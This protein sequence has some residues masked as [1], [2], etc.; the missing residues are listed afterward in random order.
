MVDLRSGLRTKTRGRYVPLVRQ[1]LLAILVPVAILLGSLGAIAAQAVIVPDRDGDGLPDAAE[2]RL[3]TFLKN[4]WDSDNDGI[5]DAVEDANHNGVVD[6]GETDPA[7]PD[8]DGDGLVDGF[9]MNAAADLPHGVRSGADAQTYWHSL[10]P[11]LFKLVSFAPPTNNDFDGDG[12]VNALDPDDDND[13]VLTKDELSG[14]A[15]PG[16]AGALSDPYN[17]DS[18][19]DGL[20][21]RQEITYGTNVLNKF[22]DADTLSDGTEVKRWDPTAGNGTGAWI[23][24]GTNP[25][26][27]D[28]DHDGI[29]DGVGIDGLVIDGVP[30]DTDGDGM[31]NALD[32]DSDN[33]GLDDSQELA[34]GTDAANFDT[35]GDGWPDGYEYHL[36]SRGFDPKVADADNDGD[37][38]PN[39]VETAWWK[40]LPNSN[41]SDHDGIPDA[42]ENSDS[43][44]W[45]LADQAGNRLP[46]GTAY[47]PGLIKMPIDSDNDGLIN[48]LDSDS[49]NDGIPDAVERVGVTDVHGNLVKTDAYN[50]DTDGDSLS[51]G[52][53]LFVF[54]TDPKNRDTDGDGLSD[55][56]EI[57][58][59]KTDPLNPDTDGDGRND[60][61]GNEGLL[62]DSDGDGIVNAIDR[63]SDNDGLTDAVEDANHNGVV[64]AGETDPTNSDT[65]GDG[66]PDGYEVMVSHTDPLLADTDGDGLS[67]YKELFGLTWEVAPG[68]VIHIATDPR[69]PDTDGDGIS[70]GVE[71]NT[72][73]SNPISNDTDG[74]G[75]LDGQVLTI[76]WI[77]AAGVMDST[78][79]SED[80]SDSEQVPDGVPNVLDVNS[81]W[82]NI[83]SQDHDFRDATEYAYRLIVRN[84]VPV[85]G[86]LNPGLVD[87]DGDGVSDAD[88]IRA[89][90]DPLDARSHQS[91][92]PTWV[93]Q[94]PDGDGLYNNEEVILGT[95]PNLADTD[96]DGLWDGEELDPLGVDIQHNGTPGQPS[97]LHSGIAHLYGTNPKL[98]DSDGDGLNDLAEL[99]LGSDPNNIDSDGDGILD[100]VEVAS[101]GVDDPMKA[102]TDDDMLLDHVR[103]VADFNSLPVDVLLRASHAAWVNSGVIVVED[104]NGN[105]IVDTGETAANN[106]DTDGDN[107]PLA[108]GWPAWKSM[109]DAHEIWLWQTNPLSAT[110]DLDGDG[111]LDQTEVFTYGTDPRYDDTDLDGIKDGAEVALTTDPK[112]R[113]TDGDYLIDGYEVNK[114]WSAP[115]GTYAQLAPDPAFSPLNHDSNGDG[116]WDGAAMAMGIANA[117]GDPVDYDSDGYPNGVEAPT[118]VAAGT[119]KEALAYQT[120]GSYIGNPKS[121]DSDGDGISEGIVAGTENLLLDSDGDGADNGMDVDSDNDWI[122]DGTT[123]GLD[124]AHAETFTADLDNDGIPNILDGDSYDNDNLLD[125]LEF[126][127][128]EADKAQGDWDYDDDGLMDGNE[129]YQWF[130]NPIAVVEALPGD[131]PIAPN[132]VRV[133]G[134]PRRADT[135]SDGLWDGLE[136]GLSAY[137]TPVPPP[138]APG[139][140]GTLDSPPLDADGTSNSDLRQRDT[141]NDGL[142]DNVED[143]NA[144]GRD[145]DILPLANAT[146]TNPRDADTDDDALMDGSE[147][148]KVTLNIV[149]VPAGNDTL[150]VRSGVPYTQALDRSNPLLCDTDADGLLDGLESGL[151]AYESPEAAAPVGVH[152]TAAA[153]LCL[154]N[155]P[156]PL[157]IVDGGRFTTSPKLAD[158]DGDGSPDGVEDANLNGAWEFPV[159]K[160]PFDSAGV[161]VQFGVAETNPNNCD[162][163]NDQ[164]MDGSDL[165]PLNHLR[166]GADWD[167][168]RQPAHFDW[169]ITQPDPGATQKFIASLPGMITLYNTFPPNPN[170]DAADGPSAK[171][172]V[173][174]FYGLAS[175]FYKTEDYPGFAEQYAACT[176]IPSSAV[177]VT[178]GAAPQASCGDL[179]SAGGVPVNLNLLVDAAT[180]PGVY[181]GKVYFLAS[182]DNCHTPPT[183]AGAC[184]QTTSLAVSTV[185]PYDTM[186]VSI[187]VP[188]YFDFDVLDTD[189][190]Y[191][192]AWGVGA[193]DPYQFYAGGAVANEMHLKGLIGRDGLLTGVFQ[194][195]NANGSPDVNSDAV[196]DVNCQPAF[197]QPK[198]DPDMPGNTR[199]SRVSYRFDQ[200]SGPVLPAGSWSFVPASAAYS[201]TGVAPLGLGLRD[202]VVFQLNTKGLGEC[203]PNGQ[204]EGTITAWF[205][206][207]GNGVQ[208]LTNPHERVADSFKVKIELVTPDVDITDNLE[209][210]TGNELTATVN[211]LLD[212]PTWTFRLTDATA[213][214]CNPDTWDKFGC[215]AIDS[216]SV[217]DPAKG[218]KSHINTFAAGVDPAANLTA[219]FPVYHVDSR[220][221]YEAD[222]SF[223]VKVWTYQRDTLNGCETHQYH[224]KIAT[225]PANLLALPEGKYAPYWGEGLPLEKNY[226]MFAAGGVASGHTR[227]AAGYPA[228]YVYTGEDPD[229]PEWGLFDRFQMNLQLVIPTDS[230]DVYPFLPGTSLAATMNCDTTVTLSGWAKNTGTS[231]LSGLD[232]YVPG[233]ILEGC[234][235]TIEVQKPTLDNI[236]LASH[237]ST[238]LH[239]TVT[240]T[241]CP[242]ACTYTGFVFVSGTNESR[243]GTK[244]SVQVSITINAHPALTG[245]VLMPEITCGQD[246]GFIGDIGFAITNTGN[247]DLLLTCSVLGPLP[248]GV[249]TV[250]PCPLNILWKGNAE[251]AVSVNAMGLPAG[252]YRDTIRL[253]DASGVKLDVPITIHVLN[254]IAVQITGVP[255]VVVRPGQ[256]V[257]VPVTVKNTGNKQIG[258]GKVSVRVCDLESPLGGRKIPGSAAV[259]NDSTLNPGESGVVNVPITVAAGYVCGQY[260]GCVVATAEGSAA[261]ADTMVVVQVSDCLNRG[262]AFQ[263]NPV[264]YSQH[265]EGVEIR[266][267]SP[268]SVELKIYSM[269]GLLVRTLTTSPIS[270]EAVDGSKATWNLKNDDGDLVASGMYIFTANVDGKVIREKLLFV[271]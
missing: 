138:G 219:T 195:A 72:W 8:T 104:Q 200:T 252:A 43:T 233:G 166:G 124:A 225:S 164:V 168:V 256:D 35:D 68:K 257:M 1:K 153:S 54:H 162:T 176:P 70:D 121:G 90:T 57:K 7:N 49:D 44:G 4:A 202:S 203:G 40:T 100:N 243:V 52:A 19:G 13:G 128:F 263:Y 78:V 86:P 265:P 95:D 155:A 242:F 169:V 9:E 139:V 260:T 247:T 178:F 140:G 223:L 88:E 161:A 147:N 51:D 87:T 236:S 109:D 20:T 74:D 192:P 45:Y 224:L 194:L 120:K 209:S 126:T 143:A 180:L 167:L 179:T 63:D 14:S 241:P 198:W 65:D 11:G 253:T 132:A 217:F 130:F 142:A 85:L 208:D 17:K 129:Y 110:A 71:V 215:E 25:L 60:G 82:N 133:H 48:A 186:D 212:L 177:Q 255:V 117:A 113:D 12:L 92:A 254:Y 262:I 259:A 171:Q 34:L 127:L 76:R 29:N 134:D 119:D 248:A 108:P 211:P 238:G 231:S 172:T 18:D 33:D 84:G 189:N 150:R 64:D 213:E 261:T 15:Y 112:N 183:Q 96:G 156:A 115:L 249:V 144:N 27:P 32:V 185:V 67:D 23:G 41:D 16:Y 123:V 187:V 158:T 201:G 206:E 268:S 5:P 218:L 81:D 22:S 210:L 270:S 135:D 239:L 235:K 160:S 226:V 107:T 193:S 2:I 196:N 205:D 125:P 214:S 148:I 267:G 101:A 244:D 184:G 221:N 131:A 240:S 59:Y 181:T 228:T 21:D 116:M 56:A 28:S 146:E 175:D 232:A 122:W 102:D 246:N 269:M 89:G 69:N 77:N 6:P 204:F 42:K 182:L 3:G 145:L 91:V 154:P 39:G 251:L 258:Q 152:G 234:G 266:V 222:K 36:A 38:L 137:Q 73:H 97:D 66:L 149:H 165:Q 94:D 230:I 159:G 136:A 188:P 271:K 62:V 197:P 237:D 106:P 24:W 163:D 174:K 227:V 170:P 53:E 80:N 98:A 173:T 157:D 30:V 46:A 229:L 99:T 190:D 141:D 114:T 191:A 151:Q 37:G 10:Q 216:V 250:S 55:G 47:A 50:A 79:Y 83:T 31:I 245:P 199:L 111:L 58:D 220:G 93:N 118:P 105:G 207:N 264:H 103:T 75:I 26:D 61:L